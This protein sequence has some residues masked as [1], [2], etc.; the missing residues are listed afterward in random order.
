MNDAEAYPI[1]YVH[2][3]I[4]GE[5]FEWPGRW[6]TVVIS[7]PGAIWPPPQ[8]LDAAMKSYQEQVLSKCEPQQ[9][10]GD[11]EFVEVSAEL[12]GEFLSIHPFREGNARAIKLVNDL[13]ATQTGRPLLVYDQS[14]SGVAT[15]IDAAKAA[16]G[17]QDY[18]PTQSVIWPALQAALQ[19]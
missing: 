16:L 6:R 13:L 14:V 11:D 10:A 12:Q 4:F 19:D 7:K 3:R 8:Y 15:Y 2:D 1:R 17:N 9:L 5:L 18:Q